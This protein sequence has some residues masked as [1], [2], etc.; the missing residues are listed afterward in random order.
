[1]QNQ[2]LAHPSNQFLGSKG[3]ERT[4]PHIALLPYK[5]QPSHAS[6]FS[7]AYWCSKSMSTVAEYDTE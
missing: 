4:P 2:R 1:M 7:P 6:E 3:C 5:L